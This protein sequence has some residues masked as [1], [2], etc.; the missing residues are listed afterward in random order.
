VWRL[1]LDPFHA[2]VY[3][4]YLGNAYY[5]IGNYEAAIELL[6]TGASRMSGY[7]PVFVWLAAAAA[8][9]GRDDEA[10]AA[11]AEVLRLQ[12]EFTITNWLQLLR[13][14]DRM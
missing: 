13:L 4:Q 7:R 11:A 9:L 2:S 1:R 3:F 8:Q 12:P 6:R 5:L 10:R 14:S